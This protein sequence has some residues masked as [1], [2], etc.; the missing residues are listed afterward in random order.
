[1]I[2]GINVEKQTG[3]YWGWNPFWAT[4]A[5]I[6]VALPNNNKFYLDVGWLGGD[7]HIF[8]VLPAVIK[9]YPPAPVQLPLLLPL[10]GPLL[11]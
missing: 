10:P 3:F 9:I 4:H 11:F 5:Y 7:D 2:Q 6:L 1:M 8:F